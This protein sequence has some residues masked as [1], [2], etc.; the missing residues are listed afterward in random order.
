MIQELI[1]NP[2]NYLKKLKKKEIVELLKEADDKYTNELTP[3]IPDNIYDIVYEYLK[4]LDPKNAYFKRIGA[5]EKHKTKL[6]FW[7]GS[8]D[9]LKDNKEINNWL[10]KY[11]EPNTYIISEK[12][13][14]ISCLVYYINNEIK[15][16]TR[17][18]GIEGQDISHLKNINI[19]KFK[20]NNIAVR[21]ELIISK[22]NW[23]LIKDVGANVRNVVA[24]TIHSKIINKEIMNKIEFVAYDLIYPR[25]SIEQ[26]L[27]F[28]KNLG[29]NIVK[30]ILISNIETNILSCL[31]EDW[32]KNSLYDIDGIVITHNKEYEYINNNNPKY[33]F[34]FK[35]LLT[36]E[37]V[38]VIVTEVE[39]NV[40]KDKYLKPIV[41]FNEILLNNVKIKKASGFN[42][43]FIDK[44]KI[45]PG[46]KIIIIRSGDV[47][48][49]ILEV[50][51]PSSNN[52]PSMPI[53]PYIWNNTHVDILMK[54]EDKNKEHDIKT[55]LFFMKTLKIPN[56][57]EG[58]LNK[59]YDNGFD[60][61]KKI[62]NIKKEELLKIDGFKE[63]I[64]DKILESLKLIYK[65]NCIDLI[66]ASNIFG[67]GIGDKKI[68]LIYEKYPYILSD[69]NKFL[70]LT[71]E[72][73]NT[74]NGFSTI[75]SKQF[76]D[77]INDFY[78]FYDDLDIKCIEDE[79][80][81]EDIEM[82][83]V[84]S[85]IRDK[86]L[87]EQIIKNK[88]MIN[89]NITKKTTYLIVSDINEETGKIKKAIKMNIPIINIDDFKK[90]MNL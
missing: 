65:S 87:E 83:I 2:I 7:M 78:K 60:T 28:I 19:P 37:K 30:N 40:S 39:W 22:K 32:R 44:N 70:K 10:L 49:H 51:T 75:T 55:F 57:A 26:S 82:I 74:I 64:T 8:L 80:K 61:L 17:G 47:I 79:I 36:Q 25:K 84:F 56:I 20:E 72:D 85:G 54:D 3:L 9:K 4:K 33:S 63:T 58:I 16:Y 77:K 52:N 5:D 14:G 42:A 41:K 69:R 88:G 6:P 66:N 1:D 62:I 12:L 18:N 21:G 46:S 23:E 81:K 76:L 53:I 35:S 43:D 50:L 11:N 71:I 48:P 24:G 13:D 67:R 90:K 89:D 38:E 29:F 73:L 15:I 59:L 45:G 34:A 31:L 68:K 27:E 86:E